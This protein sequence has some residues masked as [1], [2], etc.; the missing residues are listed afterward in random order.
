MIG[1]I[2]L[3]I[4]KKIKQEKNFLSIKFLEFFAV[5]YCTNS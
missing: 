3:Y 4:N 2:K 1:K 5:K